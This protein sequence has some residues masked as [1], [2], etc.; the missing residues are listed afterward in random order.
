MQW[1]TTTLS[2]R[3]RRSLDGW[4]R[5]TTP[6]PN[7]ED[8]TVKWHEIRRQTRLA[9]SILL[10][11]GLLWVAGAPLG[12]LSPL[13]ASMIVVFVEGVL[14][15]VLGLAFT[16][17]GW[18]RATA[19]LLIMSFYAGFVLLQIFAGGSAT[20]R[21][22]TFNALILPLLIAARL[23][24]PRGLLAVT[25]VNI[26]LMALAVYSWPPA[27]RDSL[28][29]SGTLFG[30]IVQPVT[31]QIVV[32]LLGYLWVRSLRTTVE[33]ATHADELADVNANLRRLSDSALEI[34]RLKSEATVNMS[35]VLKRPLNGM[36]GLTAQ[37]FET[38]PGSEQMPLVDG[39]RTSVEG[40]LDA[41]DDL[42]DLST[43]ERGTVEP[44]VMEFAP[45]EAVEGIADMLLS[46]AASKHLSLVTFV[47]P[48]VPDVVLGDQAR[49]R[50]VLLRLTHNALTFTEQGEVMVRVALSSRSGGIRGAAS[51]AMLRFEVSDTGRGIPAAV[52]KRL[53]QPFNQ[54]EG[55]DGAGL[56]LAIT[57]RLVE[58][59]GGEIGFEST[60]GVG[61][62]FWF[63]AR[64]PRTEGKPAAAAGRMSL[65]ERHVLVVNAHRMQQRVLQ[66]YLASAGMRCESVSDGTAA[67]AALRRYGQ[68]NDP[69]DVV[70]LDLALPGTDPLAFALAMR[71]EAGHDTTRLVLLTSPEESA[72]GETVLSDGF[73]AYVDK[74]VKLAA[75][76]DM[77]VWVLEQP[78]PAYDVPA[79]FVEEVVAAAEI[80]P[81]RSAPLSSA[82]TAGASGEH[83]VMTPAAMV[84]PEPAASANPAPAVVGPAE[85]APAAAAPASSAPLEVATDQ[86]DATT[87]LNLDPTTKL[88]LDPTTRLELDATTR[89]DP[90]ATKRLDPDATTRLDPDAT[91]RLDPDATT[92][93]NLDPTTKL[94]ID[95]TI[96]LNQDA[97]RRLDLEETT[98]LGPDQLPQG[99]S[100]EPEPAANDEAPPAVEEHA[101]LAVE[102][103]PAPVSRA[104]RVLLV[105]DN[106][107]N[108]KL[109][110][111]HLQRLGYIADIA[112]DGREALDK[113]AIGTYALVLMDISMPVMDGYE[114]TRAIREMEYGTDRHIPIIAVTANMLL[115]DRE[116]CLA[117]GMDDYL[118]KPVRM[119]MLRSVMEYWVPLDHAASL[120]AGAATVP[121]S[122]SE[123]ADATSF[124]PTQLDLAQL[125][126]IQALQVPGAPDAL[127]SVLED[128]RQEAPRLVEVMR[129]A[130][131]GNWSM[132][133]GA[134]HSLKS[135]SAYVGATE[136]SV[137]CARLEAASIDNMPSNA[138]ALVR[139][140]E[141]ECERALAAIA[142]LRV[143]PAKHRSV[144]RY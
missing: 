12:F 97:A 2:M 32:A 86:L 76:L 91:T 10:V 99:P 128:F 60:E 38:P 134:A 133:H 79:A 98:R 49:L 31:M 5:L 143:E 106:S 33:R 90:D 132:L 48:E 125:E 108:Q 139:L 17:R 100:R 16:R 120:A 63:T 45:R 85:F 136:L 21:A 80:T 127:S 87:R 140:I 84:V 75:L 89:L 82:S 103:V 121:S 65:L 28:A 29:N 11:L 43:L 69:F 34:A 66:S 112:S 117:A 131:N 59:M 62:T 24:G 130:A 88:D 19:I 13:G 104:P 30:V 68:V 144:D 96:R 95:A 26:C 114:A 25:F 52:R 116:R 71:A 53:Y 55:S 77:L 61:T 107:V 119:A 123:N 129:V 137:A 126:A 20:E 51:E 50:Q 74:P 1:Q 115:G 83:A 22:V 102:P 9:S 15:L 37:L 41:L 92:R 36:L 18:V 105:D 124:L 109:G 46:L 39:L 35:R 57:K 93:L 94:D 118:A 113:L 70:L 56:S 110:A 101:P 3:M 7:A 54:T 142:A 141:R 14:V 111:L 73:A 138:E 44:E 47:A 67:L 40:M 27:I 6:E 81:V 72:Q 78:V 58:L 64:L 8:E 135:S 122:P 23:L 42:L 4:F